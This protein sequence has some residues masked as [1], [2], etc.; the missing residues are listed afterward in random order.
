[1]NKILKI[2]ELLLQEYGPQGWFPLIDLKKTNPTKTGSINGYH[3]SDYSY[4]K[5]E[6]EGFEIA[7]GCIL[8]QNTSWIQVEKSLI[9]L[10][11]LGKI[12]IELI[13]SIDDEKLKEIIKP[14]GYFNQKA[15][16][17]RNLIRFIESRN[18]SFLKGN[19][20]RDELLSVKGIG[21]ET[22]DA[23]LLYAFKKKSFVVDA[24]TKRI[25]SNLKIIKKNEKY[26]E[27]KK[28]I[29]KNIPN[30]QEIYNEFHALLVEHAKR[31]YAKNM[32]YSKDWLFEYI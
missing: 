20:T 7:L 29:E 1:M 28:I 31:Y 23:I 17:I 14:S 6:R 13:K 30:N 22:C 9:R 12:S 24:Y 10:R 25:L 15:K 8:T 2:Y 5:T 18:I 27:I 19:I 21:N 11:S 32:D 3:P 16:Y 26:K 4:P